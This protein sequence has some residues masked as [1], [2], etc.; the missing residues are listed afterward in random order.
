LRHRAQCGD[1]ALPLAPIPGARPD[2]AAS[3]RRDCLQSLVDAGKLGAWYSLDEGPLAEVLLARGTDTAALEAALAP[4]NGP[5]PMVW[6]QW[7][8]PGVVGPR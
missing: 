2:A 8:S 4:C 5:M 7:I 1:V 3:A 6:R